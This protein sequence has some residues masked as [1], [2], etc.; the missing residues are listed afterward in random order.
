MPL[1]II[2]STVDNN[3]SSG[4]GGG[5]E[6]LGRGAFLLEDSSVSGNT[7]NGQSFSS[8]GGGGIVVESNSEI[9]GDPQVIRRSQIASNHAVFD[10]GGL[11]LNG[12]STLL[13]EESEISGNT[14]DGRGGGILRQADQFASGRMRFP[15]QIRDS[16]IVG[17][18]SVW[19]GNAIHLAG[20]PF[21]GQFGHGTA[22]I[23]ES[24]EI[25]GNQHLGISSE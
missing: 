10:G 22:A 7:A 5:M 16:R 2:N 11:H 21:N 23:L 17:N 6:V 12:A 8:G 18:G 20:S 14:A 1:E 9:V 13:I 19:G 24:S 15:L 3:V 4:R 25:S